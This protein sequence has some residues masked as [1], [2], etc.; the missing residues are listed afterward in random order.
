MGVHRLIHCWRNHV[1][2]LEIVSEKQCRKQI[3]ADARSE[4]IQSICARWAQHH[5]IR[6]AHEVDV[7][8][9]RAALE[10]VGVDSA[11]CEAFEC[12]FTDKLQCTSG[13]DDLDLVARSN[14]RGQ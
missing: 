4:L 2:L 14:E 6:P 1:R 10:R 3:V 11:T 5:R 12:R 8:H 9:V 13:G 7:L